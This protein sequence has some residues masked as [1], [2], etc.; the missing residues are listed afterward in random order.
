MIF[1]TFLVKHLNNVD[2]SLILFFYFNSVLVLLMVVLIIN[3]HLV[4][5]LVFLFNLRLQFFLTHL[6]RLQRIIIMRLRMLQYNKLN[7][8]FHCPLK[9]MLLEAILHLILLHHIQDLTNQL[10]LHHALYL[11]LHR[12]VVPLMVTVKEE[13]IIIEKVKQMFKLLPKAQCCQKVILV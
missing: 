11:S 9:I 6:F 1:T 10:Q 13:G 8:Q 5:V 7:Q 2:L 4:L 3:H 12:Q